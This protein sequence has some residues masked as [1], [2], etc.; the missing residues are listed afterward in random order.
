MRT[1]TRALVPGCMALFL[2][3]WAS[4][5]NAKIL[6]LTGTWKLNVEKSSGKGPPPKGVMVKV[7]HKEPAYKY[8][9]TGTDAEGQTDQLRI[10]WR[11]RRQALQGDWTSRRGYRYL[12]AD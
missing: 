2:M 3:F 10:R 8:S 12:E 7:V 5:L 11:D 4:P 6:N 1:V 9:V